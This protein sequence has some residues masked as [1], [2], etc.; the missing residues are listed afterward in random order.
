[1]R[2][3]LGGLLAAL[4]LVAAGTSATA[5]AS[6]KAG[7]TGVAGAGWYVTHGLAETVTNK[8]FKAADPST[9]TS[10]VC[11]GIGGSL[12]PNREGGS[13]FYARFACKVTKYLPTRTPVIK[14]TLRVRSKYY[15]S[16]QEGWGDNGRELGR[17]RY[18]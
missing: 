7:P 8:A 12:A 11:Y 5:S 6:L 3:Y 10:T 15:V 9:P 18:R 4:A 13:R 14:V 17:F 16:L 2:L 1:M